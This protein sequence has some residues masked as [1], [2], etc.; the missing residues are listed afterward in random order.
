MEKKNCIFSALH[1]FEYGNLSLTYPPPNIF[2]AN[3]VIRCIPYGLLCCCAT[4]LCL[5]IFSCARHS[6]SIFSFTIVASH[7]LL[8]K[9]SVF[10]KKKKNSCKRWIK[11]K[12]SKIQ[13]LSSS[14]IWKAQYKTIITKENPHPLRFPVK[15]SGKKRA[16]ILPTSRSE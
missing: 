9:A 12:P 2:F 13:R 3:V 8:D 14:S 10:S 7:N 4:L 1:F 16:F 5:P 11:M 15:A 6:S